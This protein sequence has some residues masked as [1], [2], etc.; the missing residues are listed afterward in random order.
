[1][2]SPPGFSSSPPSSTLE[3][4]LPSE[5]FQLTDQ[6]CHMYFGLDQVSHVLWIG[7]GVTCTVYYIMCVTCTL[8]CIRCVTCTLFCIR[9]VTFTVY[10]IRCIIYVLCVLYRFLSVYYLARVPGVVQVLKALCKPMIKI[11]LETVVMKEAY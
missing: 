1:M 11:Y 10:C 6:V 8:F 2:F 5:Q 9:C 4:Q 7:T 3:F